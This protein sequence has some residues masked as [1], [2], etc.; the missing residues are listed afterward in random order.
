MVIKDRVALVTGAAIGTGRTIAL[1]LAE[2][3]AEVIIAD[4]DEAGAQQTRAL[5]TGD[6]GFV[7]ADMT[8]PD[9]IRQLIRGSHPQILINNA[10]VGGHIP[11]HFPQASPAQWAAT[12]SLNLSWDRCT[13]PRRHCA[14]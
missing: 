14:S 7:R 1:A 12:V 3:G 4:I 11:P 9:D 2:A 8:Q 6:M 5:A 10:G 13:R